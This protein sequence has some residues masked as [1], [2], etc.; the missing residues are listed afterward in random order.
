NVLEQELAHG[1][2]A[3]AEAI[4]HG[5]DR[6]VAQL[7]QK[8]RLPVV[9]SP[10]RVVGVEHAVE[11]AIGHRPDGI[12]YGRTELLQRPHGLLGA[13]RRTTMTRD[14]CRHFCAGPI[15]RMCQR[16][17][18]SV[19]VSEPLRLVPIELEQTACAIDWVNDGTSRDGRAYRMQLVFEGGDNSEVSAPAANGPE[20]VRLLVP[21]GPQDFAVRSDKVD[22][23]EIV[24][25]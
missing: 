4:D 15:G 1:C 9:E 12:Q 17:E 19:L 7:A 23:S 2:G 5:A 22:G 8:V 18:Q 10:F 3:P 11:L 20:Q 6:S 25:G 24:E 21:A 13:G 14:K 16:R